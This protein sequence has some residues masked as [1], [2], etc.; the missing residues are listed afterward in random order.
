MGM[1]RKAVVMLNAT[2]TELLLAALGLAFNRHFRRR[3]VKQPPA[4]SC[5]VAVDLRSPEEDEISERIDMH[6]YSMFRM[7]ELPTQ[8]NSALT[9]V[10]RVREQTDAMKMGFYHAIEWRHAANFNYR[11]HG[12]G[13]PLGFGTLLATTTAPC[14]CCCSCK[15]HGLIHTI[16]CKCYCIISCIFSHFFK[17][18]PAG[19]VRAGRIAGIVSRPESLGRGG[20]SRQKVSRGILSPSEKLRIVRVPVTIFCPG[21]LREL[22]YSLGGGSPPFRLNNGK[23]Y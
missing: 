3:G 10:W 13:M 18:K 20:S 7:V 2:P 6:N 9:A 12:P 8:S 19:G 17:T 21:V 16:C 11:F 15:L 1:I 14:C 22:Q 5:A 4:V 23:L